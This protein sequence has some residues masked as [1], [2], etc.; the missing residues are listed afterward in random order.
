M[1]ELNMSLTDDILPIIVDEEGE[2]L[3]E[4]DAAFENWVRTEVIPECEAFVADPSIG[5]SIDEVRASL[6]AKHA[7][8]Q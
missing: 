8:R 4:Y 7:K 2:M 1:P 5:L 3:S 6:A